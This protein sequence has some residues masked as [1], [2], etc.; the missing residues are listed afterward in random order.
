MEQTLL[1][2]FIGVLAIAVLIQSI[3]FFA[4]YK[5]IRRMSVW[6]EDLGKD[7]LRN[8]E[9]V[10]AKV[11]DSLSAIKGIAQGLKPIQENLADATQVI[12]NRVVDLDSFLA[13]VLS[14]ARSEVQRAQDA[15]HVASSRAQETLELLYNGILT[16]LNE[17]T[18]I[19]RAIR[20]GV[21]FLFRRRRNPSSAQDEEMFI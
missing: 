16:P 20:T 21:D 11:D 14:V 5:S 1:M 10:S 2:V 6:V 8:I 15:L 13:E 3:L 12:H 18:A 17:I 9:V 7:L 19:T 4:M